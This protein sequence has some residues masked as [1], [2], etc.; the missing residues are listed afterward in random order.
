[1]VDMSIVTSQRDRILQNP[2][3]SHCN[4]V[5][6]SDFSI[7]FGVAQSVGSDEKNGGAPL[8]S[9]Y[10]VLE[11]EDFPRVVLHLNGLILICLIPF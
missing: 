2:S 4:S 5:G 7:F 3:K 1:M 9:E 6:K 11:C 8:V 10:L